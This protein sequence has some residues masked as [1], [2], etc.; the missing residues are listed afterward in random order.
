MKHRYFIQL[1]YD[2][3]L[4]HGWQRQPNGITVQSKLEEVLTTILREPIITT[5]AGR[6]DT[7]VHA[8][9]FIA[10]FDSTHADLKSD[11]NYIHRFNQLL[12]KDIAVQNIFPVKKDTHARYSAISR[13]YKYY[14]V[15][16]KDPFNN[17][18][19]F[20]Y[21]PF[22]DIEAMNLGSEILKEYHD[23]TSFSKLHTNVK[24]NNCTIHEAYW[25]R[26]SNTLIFTI[27]ADRFLRN[28]VR[29][30]VGTLIELGKGKISSDN[31]RLIISNKNR[32]TAG[33]SVPAAGLFLEHI[34]Y[35]RD[36]YV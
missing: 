4:Y 25:T 6:T 14:I 3:T 15:S 9:Y 8:R 13:T 32:N 29:A 19:S 20:Y 10:H 21:K 17:K 16:E 7:G 23:F 31:L 28:M 30:I 35:P 24:T 34:D 18:Y 26:N 5:G 2:G 11:S 12:P 22:L 1:S 33:T 36:L 27:T